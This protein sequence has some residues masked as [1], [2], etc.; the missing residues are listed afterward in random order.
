MQPNRLPQQVR[1]KITVPNVRG[2]GPSQTFGTRAWLP[3]QY[4]LNHAIYQK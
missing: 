4:A 1:I 3:L 2:K